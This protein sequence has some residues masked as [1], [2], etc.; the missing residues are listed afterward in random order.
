[1][2]PQLFD[3]T[4]RFLVPS[5]ATAEIKFSGFPESPKPPQRTVTPSLNP[6]RALSAFGKTLFMTN[7]IAHNVLEVSALGASGDGLAIDA[8]G[9]RWIVPG[10]LPGDRVQVLEQTKRQGLLV[11]SRMTLEQPS[12]DRV[13]SYCAIKGCGGCMLR[14]WSPQA[15]DAWK[16]AEAARVLAKA[17]VQNLSPLVSN[18]ALEY[19]HRTRLHRA[20]GRTGFFGAASH[21]IVPFDVCKVLHPELDANVQRLLKAISKSPLSGEIEAMYSPDDQRFAI[22]V[23]IEGDEQAAQSTLRDLVSSRIVHG[24]IG[25]GKTTRRHGEPH[26][27]VRHPM[28]DRAKFFLE[29]GVF[30]Q[31]NLRMN[32]AL[33]RLV[34]ERVYG[35]VLE[36]HAGAG[37]L[38][39]GYASRAASIIASEWDE[40]AVLCLRRNVEQHGITARVVPGGDLAVLKAHASEANV[41]VVDPPRTGCKTVAAELARMEHRFDRI[42]YVSCDVATLAR[43]LT[44]LAGRYRV[45]EAIPVDM[46]FGTPHC[47]CLCVLEPIG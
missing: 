42:V 13:A 35:R 7:A 8:A 27:L 9:E 34:S 5:L 44:T 23:V 20:K 37:N 38:T 39:L 24:A 36:L 11:A 3:T 25:V 4:V 32:E 10:A 30:S 47:E 15:S 21:H 29:P 2:V 22:E 1:V 26:V 12:S 16:Q 31:A 46:F 19:R 18:R 28:F 41:L 33:V 14:E 6:A 40:Q 45:T 17:G 43:D